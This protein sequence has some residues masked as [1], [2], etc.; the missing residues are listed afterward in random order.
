MLLCSLPS[1]F[2]LVSPSNFW[3]FFVSMIEVTGV[4]SHHSSF[5][6]LWTLWE[7]QRDSIQPLQLLQGRLGGS[8]MIGCIGYYFYIS[9]FEFL[10]RS[11]ML[12]I[13]KIMIVIS[14]WR[15]IN[16]GERVSLLGSFPKG[17]QKRCPFLKLFLHINC[18]DGH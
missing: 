9:F 4:I 17:V 1:I 7:S 10:I 8:G 12:I 16:V 15:W 14:V 18:Y 3:V 2:V 11:W 5:F 6:Y 13:N